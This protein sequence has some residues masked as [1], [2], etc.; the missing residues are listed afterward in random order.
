M[1]TK[2]E[3]LSAPV[4]W[5]WQDHLELNADIYYSELERGRSIAIR[6]Q[7]QLAEHVLYFL[8]PEESENIVCVFTGDKLEWL[9]RDEVVLSIDTELE[10]HHGRI[11]TR[12]LINRVE[13]V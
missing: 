3:Y 11:V 13:E 1:I 12:Y 4:G 5:S 2:Q 10:E 7:D 6:E 8:K 9:Y